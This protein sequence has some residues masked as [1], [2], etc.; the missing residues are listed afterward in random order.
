MQAPLFFPR[1]GVGALGPRS[2]LAYLHKS[3]PEKREE[4]VVSGSRRAGGE[5]GKAV[6]VN[7]WVVGGGDYVLLNVRPEL[8]WVFRCEIRN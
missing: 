2:K 5:P 1:V 4:K 3:R 8:G 7:L 6:V